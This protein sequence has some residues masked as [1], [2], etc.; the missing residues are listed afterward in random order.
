MHTL[1]ATPSTSEPNIS[2]STWSRGCASSKGRGKIS[3]GLRSHL[4]NGTHDKSGANRSE[5]RISE[6]R[7]KRKAI[8]VNLKRYLR[9][10]KVTSLGEIQLIEV[11]PK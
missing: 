2:S 6:N 11:T 8:N 7:G 1:E 9:E 4:L 5:V 10:K 3:L